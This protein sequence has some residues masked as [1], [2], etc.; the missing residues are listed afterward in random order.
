MAPR[1]S[2]SCWVSSAMLAFFRAGELPTLATWPLMKTKPLA[3]TAGV[4][5]CCTLG[6]LGPGRMERFI[7][8]DVGQSGPAVRRCDTDPCRHREDV[9]GAGACEARGTR[10]PGISEAI[11]NSCA[12]WRVDI[13][14]ACQLCR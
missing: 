1:F 14:L 10:V 11:S 5:G 9:P 7:G 12:G 13:P 6:W 4:K 3:S 8:K 2:I